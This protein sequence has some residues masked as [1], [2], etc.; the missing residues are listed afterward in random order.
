MDIHAIREP[1]SSNEQ[2][3]DTSNE[4][5]HDDYTE[6]TLSDL[7]AREFYRGKPTEHWLELIPPSRRV[8][9]YFLQAAC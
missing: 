2:E 9:R 7:A 6:S 8:G 3:H 5:F 4:R 1:D